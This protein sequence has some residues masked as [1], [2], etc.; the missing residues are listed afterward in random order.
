MNIL[1]DLSNEEIALVLRRRTKNARL[2]G[3]GDG[4]T[5]CVEIIRAGSFATTEECVRYINRRA[6]DYK[7]RA[8]DEGT[9]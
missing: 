5:L 4:V 3:F 8:N 6:A 9:N 2:V 7:E 1:G